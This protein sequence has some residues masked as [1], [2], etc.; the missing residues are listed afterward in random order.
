VL[1][2]RWVVRKAAD[3][4]CADQEGTGFCVFPVSVKA[5]CPPCLTVQGGLQPLGVHSGQRALCGVR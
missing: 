2:E 3:G 1:G 4:K 5:H